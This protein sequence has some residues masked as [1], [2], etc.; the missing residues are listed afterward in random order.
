M[1]GYFLSESD[2]RILRA[3]A[4][5]HRGAPLADVTPPPAGKSRAR[6]PIVRLGYAYNEIPAATFDGDGKLVTAGKG[7]CKLHKLKS[8][9]SGVTEEDDEPTIAFNVGS[10]APIPDK[11]ELLCVRD[12]TL[13][14]D[15]EYQ[16]YPG[17]L[18]VPRVVADDRPR[19]LLETD[20]G[21]GQTLA[22]NGNNQTLTID[23]YKNYDTS[24]FTKVTNGVRL[25]KKGH[26]R[27]QF[28]VSGYAATSAG[29]DSVELFIVHWMDASVPTQTG[30][31]SP[32]RTTHNSAGGSGCVASVVTD[33]YADAGETHYL[34]IAAQ[35]ALW[36]FG[37]IIDGVTAEVLFMGDYGAGL[38]VSA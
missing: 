37:T 14:G 30:P 29:A 3:L 24:V 6:L 5:R 21:S 34:Q 4:Q 31:S 35:K 8:D 20:Y 38:P 16:S 2:V 18:V 25:R 27:L 26:Y 32:I 28:H 10:D 13:V 17:Y 22:N 7:E 36:Q 23:T 11:S 15:D 12:Q 1:G 19:F 33:F 9:G